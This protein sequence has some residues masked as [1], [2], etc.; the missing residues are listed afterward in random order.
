[1]AHPAAAA[2]APQNPWDGC[3]VERD[4]WGAA[5]E[6]VVGW[7]LAFAAGFGMT[8]LHLPCQGQEA[9][10]KRFIPSPYSASCTH[11]LKH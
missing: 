11:G 7:K 2:A 9:G 6:A 10:R 1:M 4:G 3:Y 8:S 5:L